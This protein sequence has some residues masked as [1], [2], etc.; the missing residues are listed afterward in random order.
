MDVSSYQDFIG[1]AVLQIE[2][3]ILNQVFSWAM[4]A[5]IMVV[6]FSFLL[7]HHAT[8]A[9]RAWFTRQQ[10]KCFLRPES[11]GD[12]TKLTNF[13]GVIRPFL[14][15]IFVW[16]AFSSAR[17]LN[18]DRDG[19][20]TALSLLA[21]LFLARL[22]T[23]QMKN[24]F[25]ARIL[26]IVIW[27][28]ASLYVFHII[29]PW[30]N[31]LNHIDFTIGKV[32]VSLL[33]ANQAL[34]LL[35]FLYWLSRN[36]LIIL[37]FWL[38]TSS[39]LSSAPQLLLYRLCE[40]FLLSASVV[41]VLHYM[42]IDLTVFAVFSGALGLGIGFGLQR[43]FANLISGF[44]ILADKSIKPG[45]V[46]QIDD[47]YGWI[48]YLGSRYISVVTRDS[49]EYLVPNEELIT[50]KVINWS[51]S[52]NLVRLKMPV[53]IAYGSDLDQAMELMLEAAKATPR[54]MIQPEPACLLIGFGESA[55]NFEIRVWIADPQNGVTNVKSKV[56]LKV[57]E[58][59]KEHGIE[60]PFP[61]RVL[62]HKSMPEIKVCPEPEK[63]E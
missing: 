7:A 57:W 20:Q 29:D 51:Y 12:L 22:L 8:A 15:F 52:N 23:D 53:G 58:R 5:Q 25:L 36:L 45:D 47:K 38:M 39:G 44:V 17:H 24:R 43:V 31:L 59:F 10:E 54:V 50:G 35:L 33:T 16:I 34:L 26:G 60:L 3:Y 62:H 55:V 21:A 37:H 1:K 4:A 18:W 40:I 9:I 48:N 61:Q 27:F 41:L 2:D 46:I 56:L 6:V 63:A 32:H 28:W 42:G 30:H 11:C 14:A 13:M 49:I 19:L